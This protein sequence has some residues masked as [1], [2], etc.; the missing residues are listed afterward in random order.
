MRHALPLHATPAVPVP[1]IRNRMPGQQAPTWRERLEMELDEEFL[2]MQ[3]EAE[4]EAIRA[5][6]AGKASRRIRL[7]S[8]AT[9]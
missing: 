2:E 7:D 8:Q 6:Y 1:T 9:Y 4:L 5:V 3:E